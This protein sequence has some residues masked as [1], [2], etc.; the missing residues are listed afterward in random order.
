MWCQAKPF[1]TGCSRPSPVIKGSSV[2]NPPARAQNLAHGDPGSQD[3]RNEP[4]QRSRV[5]RAWA[6]KPWTGPIVKWEDSAVHGNTARAVGKYL[7]LVLAS[8]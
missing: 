1:S 7:S 4:P 3:S 6:T 8:R 5:R 2:L